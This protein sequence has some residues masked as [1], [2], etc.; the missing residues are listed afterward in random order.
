MVVLMKK[1][2]RDSAVYIALFVFLFLFASCG[3][4]RFEKET[5]DGFSDIADPPPLSEEVQL[6]EEEIKTPSF[7]PYS[8]AYPS[9]DTAPYDAIVSTASLNVRKGAGTSFAPLFTLPAGQSLPYLW[10]EGAWFAVWTGERV[11]YVSRSY[12]FQTETNRALERVIEAGLAFLGTPYEWGAPRVLTDKGKINPYF[13]GASFDCS[14][15]VQYCFYAGCGVK[16]GTYTGSQADHTVG[17]RITRYSDLKR[18]DIYFTGSGSISHVV[19][20]LGGGYLLQCYSA[21]GGPVSLTKDDRWKGK[22]ISGR[23]VDLSVVDQ[24]A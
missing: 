5:E 14:S 9:S 23:R 17:K 18:G 8:Y 4:A 15:F 1:I 7:S 16:L 20:Y 6:K 24:Y 21:N 10:E 2:L 11:G 13:T 3:G 12:A 22:F 19:L